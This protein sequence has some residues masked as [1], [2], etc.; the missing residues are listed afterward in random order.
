MHRRSI[1]RTIPLASSLLLLGRAGT[2]EAAGSFN[3]FLVEV[4]RMAAARGVSYATRAAA[5]RGLQ[6]DP[7]VIQFEN[8]QPE[9]TQTWVQYSAKRLTAARITDGRQHAAAADQVLADVRARFGVDP[10]VIMGIWG[11]ETNYGS[12]TGGY[13]VVQSLA[14]LAWSGHRLAYFRDELIA[15]LEIIDS[16]AVTAAGMTGS[17]AGAMGQPQFMPSVYRRLAVSF[18][19]RG[20]PNIWT[21]IP[22]SLASIGNYLRNSGWRLGQPW[23]EPV[24]I[25]PALGGDGD[26][27]LPLG[28]WLAMGVERLPRHPWVAEDTP[29]RLVLPDGAGGASFLVYPNFK[30][31]RR[32]NPSDFYALS[33]GLLG[34]AIIA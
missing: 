2:A 9:F 34:N 21:S 32:Y 30:A 29:A 8:Y 20:R 22:D 28:R 6:P 31:I 10:G 12:Y 26:T 18:D 24:V 23:G 13:S 33:V 14:T 25:G 27:T 3:A 1:L 17:W 5:L 7:K 11:L 16:G 15:A 19:G 4:D